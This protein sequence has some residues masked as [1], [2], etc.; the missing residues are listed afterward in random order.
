MR[1]V[2]PTVIN[3]N[4]FCRIALREED[5]VGLGAA[6]VGDKG[7]VRKTQNSVKVA[8]VGE[9]LEDFA[10]LIRKQAIV[11]Q[12]HGGSPAWFQNRH[13]MLNE[14][15]LVVAGR[16]REIVTGRGLVCPLRSER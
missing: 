13:D 10:R 11:W 6:T 8:V 12:N 16:N 15:K 5:H 4:S 3:P 2:C 7:S 9:N 1:N 14:V